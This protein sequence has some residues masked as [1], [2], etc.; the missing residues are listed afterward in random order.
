MSR[1]IGQDL[2]ATGVAQVMVV[3][4][5]PPAPESL[6]SR[7]AGASV[8]G[9]L[10]HTPIRGLERHFRHSDLSQ[11]SALAASSLTAADAVAPTVR[12][13]RNLG[14]ALGIVDRAGLAAL[15]ADP[16]VASV[17]GAPKFSLIAPERIAEAK[18]TV[19]QTWGLTALKAP[20]LWDKGFTGQGVLVGHLD[21]GVDGTHPALKGAIGA[22]AEFDMLGFELTPSP[23]PRDSGDHGTHTAATIAGRAVK[24]RSVGM[25]P[26]AKVASAMVIEGGNAVARVL[27]GMDW[28]VGLRVQVLSMSLGFR[29]WWEDFI[30]IA[31]ILRRHQILPVFA[32][33]NEGPGTSRSPGNYVQALS[34]G[35]MEPNRSVASFS[36]SQR[37][38]RRRDPQVPDIIGPGV[39]IT[40]ARPGGGWQDM[41]GT[42]MATPHIAGLAAL[43]MSAR[44]DAS[45]GRIERA[46]FES[47]TLDPSMPRD[48]A[49]RGL[50]DGL[51]A[52]A[53]L[54]S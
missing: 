6:G 26:D 46:I 15:R 22:Y 8:G 31:R 42:S 48:R 39:G 20:D 14:V 23:A 52:L 18:L 11:D 33:G 1:V 17:Q 30:P 21:T 41:D 40:S 37:F 44:P 35:A 32:V 54:T 25:A 5:Q 4:R 2:Q 29:G 13:Y 10:R 49:N 19:S 7:R 36:S 53:L 12:Y 9:P 45:V 27:G 47:C 38:Q 51:K 3:L 50:P 16:A 43:L 28:A 34:V 24:G